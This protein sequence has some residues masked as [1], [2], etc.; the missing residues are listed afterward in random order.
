MPPVALLAGGLAT[1]LRPLT[2]QVPKAKLEVAGEPFIAHQLRLLRREN[3]PRVVICAG[4]LAEQI[5][6]YVGDGSRFGLNVSYKID[7]PRLLGTGG[8]LRAALDQLGAEFLVMY[9]D[10]WLDIPYAPVVAA[11]HAS[12]QRALMTVFRNA[13]RW[14]ASNVWFEDGRIRLYSKRERLPQMQHID[15]GLSAIRAEVLAAQ[16]ADQPF[17]LAEIYSD[18]SRE[19]TLAGY[20]VTTRFY[21]IGSKEGLKETDALLRKAQSL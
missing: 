21:E 5:S 13:G 4:Y 18:L 2:E 19:G 7:G 11:F 20:E 9:G 16:P 1:R 8:A 3:I 15:W 17:D 12:R 6:A 14:D 10:S